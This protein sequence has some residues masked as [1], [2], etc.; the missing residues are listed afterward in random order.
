MTEA[1]SKKADIKRADNK[2]RELLFH[3]AGWILFI[4]CA[5]FFIFSSFRNRD[6][7]ALIGSLLFLVACV[8]FLFPLVKEIRAH[9]RTFRQ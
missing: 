9:Y 3:L 1:G 5:V 6:P 8:V 4:L 7:L 2:W